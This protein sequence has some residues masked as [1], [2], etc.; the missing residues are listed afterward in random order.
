METKAIWKHPNGS[1]GFTPLN[2]PSSA[3]IVSYNGGTVKDALDDMGGVAGASAFIKSLLK[4]SDAA[5]ARKLLKVSREPFFDEAG[6]RWESKDVYLSGEQAKFGAS[7]FYGT[8][9]SSYLAYFQGITLGGKDF[10]IAFWIYAPATASSQ[11]N[12]FTWGDT[13]NRIGVARNASNKL[14]WHCA[15]LA[16]FSSGDMS[17][18]PTVS[19]NAWHHVEIDYRNSDNKIFLFFNGSLTDTKTISAFGTSFTLPFHLGTNLNNTSFAFK[20]YVD[21]FLI[22]GKLLHTASFT[23]PTAPYN[24]DSSTISLLHFE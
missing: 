14:F 24:V 15:G 8:G 9:A 11:Q 16:T 22:T 21:E 12:F 19:L 17:S 23:P 1:G 2:L 4:A 20:G 7:S 5:A 3:E 6:K 10:S 13:T 18:K